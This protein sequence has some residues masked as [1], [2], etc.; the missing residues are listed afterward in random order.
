MNIA[1]TS[2]S[3]QTWYIIVAI[4][5]IWGFVEA[6]VGVYLRGS[7]AQMMTGS[8]L[9]GTTMLFFACS[10]SFSKK[11]RYLF[12]MPVIASIF[13]IS[14]AFVLDTP[15][16]SGAI[17]NP[18]F[19]FFTEMFGFAMIL[20]FFK[21]SLKEKVLGQATIGAFAALCAVNLFPLVKYCT[22][23]SACVVPGTQYPLSL[24]GAPIAV[25][26]SVVTVPIGFAVGERIK[27]YI[28]GT[29]LTPAF[30]KTVCA[31]VVVLAFIETVVIIN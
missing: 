26:L 4:A 19:A 21:N 3:K 25:G 6:S 20:Y 23:I 22:G 29:Q 2:Q 1:N 15:I 13:K 8:L 14:N 18:I 27:E 10:Y 16:I 30:V 5:S 7:C 17:A 24:W 28:A 31:V 9:T 11:F 12:V